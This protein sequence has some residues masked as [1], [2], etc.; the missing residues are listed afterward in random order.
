MS[1]GSK[2]HDANGR[3]ADFWPILSPEHDARGRPHGH[4]DTLE[5]RAVGRRWNAI[6]LLHD[7]AFVG[8][9]ESYGT[10]PVSSL[11]S[12][13]AMLVIRVGICV[14]TVTLTVR[15]VP[16]CILPR[17]HETCPRPLSNWQLSLD[18]AAT[19]CATPP[20]DQISESLTP[21]ALAGPLFVTVN[22]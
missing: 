2:A 4:G 18:S 21:V 5:P 13:N 17:V 22:V 14:R 12:T 8:R 11:L 3:F 15:E 20:S 1:V 19:N 9:G 6:L 16:L 7:K 10:W